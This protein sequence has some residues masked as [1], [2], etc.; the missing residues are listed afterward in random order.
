M[1][2]LRATLVAVMVS[3]ALVPLT[4]RAAPSVIMFYGESLREPAFIV[5]RTTADLDKYATFWCG[6]STRL[7]TAHL[8]PR[9]YVNV[10]IFSINSVW[11][12]PDRARALLPTLK[13]EDAH[14]QGRLYAP[15][16]DGRIRAAVVTTDYMR[17]ARKDDVLVPMTTPVPVDASQFKYG[18]WLNGSDLAVA[19]DLGLPGFGDSG[20]GHPN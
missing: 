7:A 10:A 3:L 11:S 9:P 1:T 18:C 4:G 12:D 6:T 15:S 5:Q 16:A 14:Q 2:L 20:T 19:R 13:P 8:T 17:M